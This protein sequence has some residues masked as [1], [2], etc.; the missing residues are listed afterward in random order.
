MK[1]GN[2]NLEFKLTL[3]LDGKLIY[4][5]ERKSVK[6]LEFIFLRNLN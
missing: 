6:K 3:K 4:T 2:I 5:V 1:A